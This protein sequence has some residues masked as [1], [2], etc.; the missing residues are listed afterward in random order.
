[1]APLPCKFDSCEKPSRGQGFC[2]GHYK[3]HREGKTLRPLLPYTHNKGKVC[4]GP[5]C[6]KM[7]ESSG[8]CTGHKAQ[9]VRNVELF[10]L[11]S[12]NPGP[13]PLYRDVPCSFDGCGRGAVANG[14]CHSHNQQLRRIGELRPIGWRPPKV[15]T[16]CAFDGCDEPAEKR[17]HCGT[18]Y[19]QMYRYGRTQARRNPTGRWVDPNSGYAYVKAPDNPESRKGRG[20][21]L[22]HRVVMSDFLGRPLWPE[23]NVHHRNGVR[24]DNRIENLELWTRSQP[25][26]QRVADK[27]AW[28]HELIAKYD[29]VELPEG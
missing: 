27:L 2:P 8:L 9:S 28:A 23:E 14:L 20:W 29:G 21:G 11:G 5:A 4:A 25:S 16:E 17:G 3:Q 19:R 13:D 15:V 1:M 22:E 24:D 12:R 26:G 7:A 6:T 18:H 10:P